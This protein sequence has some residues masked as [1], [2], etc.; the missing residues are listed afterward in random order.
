VSKIFVPKIEKILQGRDAHVDGM[1]TVACQLK[2]NAALIEEDALIALENAQMDVAT[3]EAKFLTAFWE[4]CLKEKNS[5]YSL[6]SKKSKRELDVLKKSA[7]KAY[8]DV[9]NRM[10][11]LTNLVLAVLSSDRQVS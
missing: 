1:L 5:L 11:E 4:Q 3:A 2:S 8:A 10:D 7:Q 9:D 6:F